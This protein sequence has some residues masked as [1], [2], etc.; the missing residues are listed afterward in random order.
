MKQINNNT[1]IGWNNLDIWSEP[2]VGA[3]WIVKKELPQKHYESEIHHGPLS[4]MVL[5][6]AHHLN[7]VIFF[8]C[9]REILSRQPGQFL[10]IANNI[11][12]VGFMKAFKNWP[13]ILVGQP[14][15]LNKE[16]YSS[17]VRLANRRNATIHSESALTSL[18]MARSAL[19]TSII[20]SEYIAIHLLGPNGFVYKDILEKYKIDSEVMFSQVKFPE[21]IVPKKII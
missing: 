21:D 3:Q 16:P 7:E 11:N 2:Y 12:R 8:K 18:E 17:V 4:Q 6:I 13:E 5:L 9:V 20:S 14:F 15:D 1:S 19:Y 10:Q